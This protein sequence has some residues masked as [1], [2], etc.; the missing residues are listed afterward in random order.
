[1][2]RDTDV[3]ASIARH[4]RQL[5]RMTETRCHKDGRLLGATYKLPD[6]TWLWSA[7]HRQLP[8]LARSEAAAIYL[9]AIEDCTT[10][11]KRQACY[12]GAS[13]ALASDVRPRAHHKVAKIEIAGTGGWRFARPFAISTVSG[14][15]FCVT[16]V[17][18]G[19]RRQYLLNIDALVQ[20]STAWQKN[21]GQP[22]HVA[23]LPADLPEQEVQRLLR[24]HS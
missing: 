22:I 10:D 6:G 5:T 8:Q 4:A 21:K 20:A 15:N 16:D 9:D 7:G 1:M 2:D 14:P 12:D 17:S 19:C 13:E 18:C 11:E 24:S 3:L 23:P